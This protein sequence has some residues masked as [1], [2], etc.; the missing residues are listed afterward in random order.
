MGIRFKDKKPGAATG[1][2]TLD[3]DAGS[4]WSQ[5]NIKKGTA[6]TGTLA[7]NGV[8]W[9]NDTP[10]VL[11]DKYGAPLVFNMAALRTLEVKGCWE[12]F[13]LEP[14]GLNGTYTA[15]YVNFE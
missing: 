9:G 15:N 1:N 11:C 12:K 4:S 5:I 13:V 2:L 3:C 7:L 6:T 14:S 10:E 8:A